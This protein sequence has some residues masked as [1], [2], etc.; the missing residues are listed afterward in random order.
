M[1]L[2]PNETERFAKQESDL[3]ERLL[4]MADLTLVDIGGFDS[5]EGADPDAAVRSLKSPKAKR[6]YL[7]MLA[8]V[9]MSDNSL[10]PSEKKYFREKAESMGVGTIELEQLTYDKAVLTLERVIG[11]VDAEEPKQPRQTG[12]QPSDIDLM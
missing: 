1:L 9:A 2:W 4:E 7:L 8:C 5:E 6:A 3:I 10:A 12:A 11:E